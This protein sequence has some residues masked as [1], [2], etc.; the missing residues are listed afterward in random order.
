MAAWQ[1]FQKNGPITRLASRHHGCF[2]ID[3]EGMDRRA[4]GQAV[5]ILQG[6]DNPLVVFPE[7]EVYHVNDRVTPFREGPASIALMAAR[8]AQRPIACVPCALKYQY[9]EDPT[10]NL[11]TLME[12][13]EREIFWRPR[14]DLPLPQRIYRFAEA[15]LAIKELEYLGSTSAGL[16]P[17]RIANL[18]DAIL[19]QLESRH[20]ASPAAT[21]V[22]ERVKSLRQK[23]IKQ[24][25]SLQEGDGQ[26][27]ALGQDLD[28]LFLVVQLFSY[29]GDYVAERPTIER[30]AETLD[31][32]EEDVL[33]ASTAT[34]RAARRAIVQFG[35]PIT[36][37]AN[38]PRRQA[39]ATLTQQ[40]EDRVQQML[41][42]LVAGTSAAVP[43][44][45]APA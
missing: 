34:V 28:D 1:V 7:G 6:H 8:K 42:E 37:E 26:R 14:G 17:E 27:V 40:L 38:S 15:I 36:V 19:R 4:L 9:V 18:S 31:K 24:I 5:E 44:E 12:S 10:P 2:S 39:A 29:P 23:V 3:R 11:Q 32:F 45:L 21:T 41:N 35:E 13:L 33:K 43:A 25:E 16:L 30:L 22:P 20:G